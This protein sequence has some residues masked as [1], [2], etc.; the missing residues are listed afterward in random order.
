MAIVTTAGYATALSLLWLNPI[1][2]PDSVRGGKAASVVEKWVPGL[3]E[4][5][6]QAFTT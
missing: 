1:Y 4:T 6:A 5:A 3:N 2:E